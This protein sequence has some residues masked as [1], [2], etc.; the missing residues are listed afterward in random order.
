MLDYWAYEI[1]ELSSRGFQ[2]IA[3]DLRGHGHSQPASGGDYALARF[4]ED[5]EA[6]LET[7]LPDDQRAVVVGHS[8]GAMSLA[9]WAEHHDVQRRVCAAAMLNTGV[10]ELLAEQLLVPVPA[11]AQLVNRLIPPT[12]FLGSSAPLPRFSTPLSYALIRYVAFGRAASPAQIAFFERMLVACPP[13]VRADV[14]MAMSEMDLYGALANLTVPVLVVAGA[15]DKLTPPSHAK[16]IAESVPN[17]HR[18]VVLEDTG[19]MGPL[20]RPREI[21][22]AVVELAQATSPARAGSAA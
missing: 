18:L 15:D 3:Y 2:V 16:R 14:G 21:T 9:A 6:V 1:R 20:E 10:G 19:H 7:C 12:V 8:L 4:G 22:E 17:L 13:D 5:L 11:L